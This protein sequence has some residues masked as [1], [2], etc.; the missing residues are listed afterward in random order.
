MKLLLLFIPFIMLASDPIPLTDAQKL[1]VRDAQLAVTRAENLKLTAAQ[2]YMAADK[3]LTE[4]SEKLAKLI[5][6][7]TPCE[8]C[9][10]KDD[11][12]WQTPKKPVEKPKEPKQ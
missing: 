9:Q 12:T 10:L 4:A 5:K 11:L 8:G 6:D 1:A 3:Q 7:L 2:Q